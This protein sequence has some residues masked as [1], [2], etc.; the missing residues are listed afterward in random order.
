MKRILPLA[1][2][3]VGMSLAAP[4]QEA[5]CTFSGTLGMEFS[6]IPVPPATLDINT[7]ITLG[8][9]MGGASV[10][11]RTVLSLHGLEEEHFK[12]GVDLGGITLTT[13][14]RF[15]PCFSKYWFEVRG[16]CCPFDLG[17]LFLVENLAAACQTPDYTVGL[18]LDLG[19]SFDSGFFVRSTTGFGVEDL[20]HLIDDDPATDLTAVPG[21]WF[22]E[23]LLHIG[24]ATQCLRTESMFLFDELGFAWARFY[25]SYT[26]QEPVIELGARVWLNSAFAFSQADLIL[27]ITID[28]VSLKSITSFDWSGFLSQ[29]IDISISFSGIEL[30]SR[31]TFDF[32]GL[33]SEVIGFTLSF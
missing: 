5:G 2:V 17:A 29:E 27:G 14:M 20:Y 10:E 21:W 32:T 16:G 19:L 33:V 25:A 18:V 9:T 1:V 31:T 12:M 26:W 4:A 3:L 28:P 7:A 13:G 8:L 23:E 11:S 15:D 22:E 6:F 24:F 30:Y